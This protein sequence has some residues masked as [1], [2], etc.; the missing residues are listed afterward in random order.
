MTPPSPVQRRSTS[1][2]GE[3]VVAGAGAVLTTLLGSCVA[4]CVRDPV[5]GIGGMNHFLL[6]G[7]E[8]GAQGRSESYGVY[9]MEVLVNGLLKRGATRANLEA[10][11]FGG[12]AR[13]RTSATSEAGTS[14]SRSASCRP[15]GYGISAETSAATGDGAWNTGRIPA[16]RAA[17]SSI[18]PRPFHPARRPSRAAPANW[19][20]SEMGSSIAQ[21]RRVPR[22]GGRAGDPCR[23]PAAQRRRR[24]RRPSRP[25]SRDCTTASS[26]RRATTTS[27]P[28]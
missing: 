17:S 26:P 7:N 12:G 24:T 28:S 16:G 5:L 2:Q 10:K 1:L 11:L 22:R 15:K 18:A 23:A 4:A 8:Q 13:S 25:R 3:A 6:P 27:R 14:P 19:S 21:R 20:C 9:L